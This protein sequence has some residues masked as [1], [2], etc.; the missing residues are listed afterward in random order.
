MKPGTGCEREGHES[1]VAQSGAISWFFRISSGSRDLET[2]NNIRGS[3]SEP[4]G[5][6]TRE[7]LIILLRTILD[8]VGLRQAC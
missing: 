5:S 1:A 7:Y 3:R 2:A 6:V 8:V 4:R